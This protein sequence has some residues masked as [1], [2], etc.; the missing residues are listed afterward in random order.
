[1]KTINATVK[2]VQPTA[3][4]RASPEFTTVA[5]M[6]G[7]MA[8]PKARLTAALRENPESMTAE[9]TVERMAAQMATGEPTAER[10]H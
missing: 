2:K 5:P 8:E 7:R 10:S 1:M 9:P 6:A 3:V 4:L